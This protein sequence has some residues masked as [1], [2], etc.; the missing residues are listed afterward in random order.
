MRFDQ[1]SPAEATILEAMRQY[2]SHKAVARALGKSSKTVDA[3]LCNIR[4]KLGTHTI[5]A[6]VAWALHRQEK[7]WNS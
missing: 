5:G 3:H 4:E 2:G 7:S 6:V 1:I